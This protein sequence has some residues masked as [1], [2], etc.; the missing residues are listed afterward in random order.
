MLPQQHPA[1]A[2]ENGAAD[3][4]IANVAYTVDNRSTRS[5]TATTLLLICSGVLCVQ[6]DSTSP[7]SEMASERRANAQ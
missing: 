5:E 1:V 2:Y 4:N 6:L 7:S 3:G